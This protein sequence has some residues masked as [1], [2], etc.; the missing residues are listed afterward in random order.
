MFELVKFE[1]Y[2]IVSRKFNI[3]ALSV[4]ILLYFLSTSQLN[5]GDIQHIRNMY[6]EWNSPLTEERA[7]IARQELDRKSVV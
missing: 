5:L 2:K 4:F 7:A 3:L 6:S 1:L